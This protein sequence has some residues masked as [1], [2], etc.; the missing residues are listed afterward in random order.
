MSNIAT[1]AEHILVVDDEARIRQMLIRYFEGEGYRVS[2][3]A[4][5]PAMRDCL[6]KSAVDII[7][8]DLALPGGEDGLALARD[9]RSRSNI[10]II[11]LTGRDDVID[12]DRG[13][14][15]GRRRLYCQA[16]PP[17]GSLGACEECVAS[18]PGPGRK[19]R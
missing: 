16:I 15:G 2:A 19:R 14:G 7:L 4:D 10:P 12:S 3:A 8:L 18:P 1:Q 17:A 5:G 11:M 13:F 9:I 6:A